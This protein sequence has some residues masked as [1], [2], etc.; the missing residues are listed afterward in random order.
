LRL[1]L[2]CHV[3]VFS[4]SNTTYSMSEQLASSGKA[5][6]LQLHEKIRQMQ[7]TYP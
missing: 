6:L 7:P 1:R 3:F 5:L 4:P 2:G